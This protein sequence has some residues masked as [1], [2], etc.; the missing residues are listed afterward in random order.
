MPARVARAYRGLSRY[1]M[2]PVFQHEFLLADVEDRA[3]DCES[4]NLKFIFRF[5]E[6]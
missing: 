3:M 2:D 6:F 4:S 1:L 5:G